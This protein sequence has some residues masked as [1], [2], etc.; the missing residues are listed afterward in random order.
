MAASRDA[1]GKPYPRMPRVETIDFK[2]FPPRTRAA[3]LVNF[4]ILLRRSSACGW[5]RSRLVVYTAICQY[6]FQPHDRSTSCDRPVH[7]DLLPYPGVDAA[8]HRRGGVP[9]G[10]RSE[11][12]TSE[13][14]SLMRI[15]YAV[16]CLKKQKYKK[17]QT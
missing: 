14:Q 2:A 15:S 9:A 3:Q 8:A 17:K 4:A 5:L 7:A 6:G 10:R 13:L 11:E 16:F 12:H 1:S